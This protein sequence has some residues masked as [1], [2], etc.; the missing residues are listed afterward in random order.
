MSFSSAKALVEAE[1]KK[2]EGDLAQASQMLEEEQEAGQKKDRNVKDLNNRI[3]D[4]EEEL[5]VGLL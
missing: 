2:R 5:E 4:L 3:H 1:L